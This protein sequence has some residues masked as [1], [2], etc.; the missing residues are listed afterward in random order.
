[1]TLG[2]VW[3]GRPRDTHLHSPFSI[4]FISAVGFSLFFFG[5]FYYIFI[6]PLLLSFIKSLASAGMM[7]CSEVLLRLCSLRKVCECPFFKI[8]F[9]FE[10]CFLGWASFL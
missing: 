2:R 10:Y 6:P 4:Y 3:T 7:E 1:M 9:V 8:K 5:G